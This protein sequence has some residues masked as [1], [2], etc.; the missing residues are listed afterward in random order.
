MVGLKDAELLL[1]LWKHPLLDSKY[2]DIIQQV[3]VLG[4]PA[5]VI[6]TQSGGP[7]V[8]WKSIAMVTLGPS[9]GMP[10]PTV[11]SWRPNLEVNGT[12]DFIQVDAPRKAT[13]QVSGTLHRL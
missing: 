3:Q 2:G 8:Q 12:A 9:T 10:P 1:D 11:T 5:Q 7:A 6:V 13:A 4:Q